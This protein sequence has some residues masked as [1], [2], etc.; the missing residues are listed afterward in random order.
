[1]ET[2]KKVPL[3]ALPVIVSEGQRHHTQQSVNYEKLLQKTC[4][5]RRAHLLREKYRRTRNPINPDKPEKVL[6]GILEG[7]IRETDKSALL[8]LF[9]HPLSLIELE[10]VKSGSKISRIVKK[11][12]K[13]AQKERL[14]KP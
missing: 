8:R 1:M 5:V 14:K 13:R 11:A 2:S 10:S 12:E 9:S 6:Q 7:D 3:S 4:D